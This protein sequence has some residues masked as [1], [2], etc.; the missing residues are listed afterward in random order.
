MS[1]PSMADYVSAT[2]FI[3]ARRDTYCPVFFERNRTH[4]IECAAWAEMQRRQ[5]GEW[6]ARY[7]DPEPL[8]WHPWADVE[9]RFQSLR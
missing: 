6:K 5:H 4:L 2:A 1:A 3:D 7:R 8:G 9:R